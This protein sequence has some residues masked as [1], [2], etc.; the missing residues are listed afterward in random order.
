MYVRTHAFYFW[1]NDGTET[2]ICIIKFWGM[3][4]ASSSN[5]YVMVEAL[6][7]SHTQIAVCGMWECE[8]LEKLENQEKFFK[9]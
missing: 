3:I 7:Y 5:T 2:W 1:V 6:S 8:T 4:P 9:D